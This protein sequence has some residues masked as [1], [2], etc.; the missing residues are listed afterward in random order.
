M[1]LFRS[2]AGRALGGRP[3][4]GRRIGSDRTVTPGKGVGAQPY[5]GTSY[6]ADFDNNIYALNGVAGAKTTLYDPYRVSSNDHRLIFP[7][8]AV[9]VTGAAMTI[10]AD[11]EIPTLPGSTFRGIV[12]VSNDAR[13]ERVNLSNRP[14]NFLLSDMT[15]GG[16]AQG[17]KIWT[18]A[19]SASGVRFMSGVAI[20][21]STVLAK[22]GADTEA[23]LTGTEPTGLTKLSI[24]CYVSGGG[25][26]DL[27]IHK[28]VVFNSKL[29]H[30]ELP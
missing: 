3:L 7:L 21:A 27:L 23:T 5:D 4:A 8:S 12:E 28:L 20:D 19:V 10:F 6:Y 25:T 14:D 26:I 13:T 17:F 11:L 29:T 15:A 2:L 9:G 18:T 16:V 24:G 22:V 1:S 30:A